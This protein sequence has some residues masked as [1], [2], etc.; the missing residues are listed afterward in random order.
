VH[1][2]LNEKKNIKYAVI[3]AW[4]FVKQNKTRKTKQNYIP[5]IIVFQIQ[6]VRVIKTVIQQDLVKG[7]KCSKIDII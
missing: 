2:D 7:G 3:F 1:K 5:L 6:I 4:T